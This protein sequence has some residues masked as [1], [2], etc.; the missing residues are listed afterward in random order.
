MVGPCLICFCFLFFFRSSVFAV[1][2]GT[3]VCIR[4]AGQLVSEWFCTKKNIY[5]WLTLTLKRIGRYNKHGSS[6]TDIGRIHLW[7]TCEAQKVC[8]PSRHWCGHLNDAVAMVTHQLSEPHVSVRRSV[9]VIVCATFD[10]ISQGSGSSV[11]GGVYLFLDTVASVRPTV[12]ASAAALLCRRNV[13]WPPDGA[14]GFGGTMLN[15]RFDRHGP[16]FD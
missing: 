2:W 15:P 10:S 6:R 8:D 14:S 16:T 4:D 12:S 13:R 5:I 9:A 11:W 7:M 1:L 3:C